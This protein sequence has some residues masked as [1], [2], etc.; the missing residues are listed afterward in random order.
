MEKTDTLAYDSTLFLLLQ[1]EVILMHWLCEL[2]EK[3]YVVFIFFP[4]NNLK[5]L[6]YSTPFYSDNPK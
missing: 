2:E 6:V 1:V 5:S 3:C 4:N